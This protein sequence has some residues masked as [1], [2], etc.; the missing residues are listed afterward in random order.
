MTRTRLITLMTLTALTLAW[1]ARA[2]EPPDEETATANESTTEASEEA[3]PDLATVQ[4][5]ASSQHAQH[6]DLA[7]KFQNPFADLITFPFQNIAT[8]GYGPDNGGQNILNIQPVVPI[9]LNSRWNLLFRPILPVSYTSWPTSEAGLGDLNLEPFFSP[10]S[11]RKLVWG[12]GTILGI[13]TAT[14]DFLGTGKWTAGPAIAVFGMHGPWTFS[15]IAN[16]QWSYAGDSARDKVSVFQLQPSLNYI[17][18]HGWYVILGPLINANWTAE[19]GQE[20]TVPLGG[21]IGK[22]FSMGSQKMGLSLEGYGN[23][24]RPDNGPDGLMILT[25]VL[26]FPE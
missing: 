18:K 22:I 5:D 19:S 21:G 26:L 6:E 10:V 20:W 3:A 4:P 23:V 9:H 1:L 16:Q 8:F 15:V 2:D 14:G 17:L 7:A 24:I 13:P 11:K 12:V 25:F